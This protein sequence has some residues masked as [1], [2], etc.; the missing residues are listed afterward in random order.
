V[1]K[2]L[3][4]EGFPVTILGWVSAVTGIAASL[5]YWLDDEGLF[6]PAALVM[7]AS[8]VV[9]LFLIGGEVDKRHLFAR[10]AF[11][12][13]LL[14]WLYVAAIPAGAVLSALFGERYLEVGLLAVVAG[15]V[16]AA[17]GALHAA[18]LDR[19]V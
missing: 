16:V 8:T 10:F 19:A 2:V 11:G 12:P 6:G 3:C 5:A 4:H 17:L 13:R 9:V 1:P 7:M 14:A 15:W 18:P